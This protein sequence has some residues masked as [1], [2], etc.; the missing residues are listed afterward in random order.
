M[1]DLFGPLGDLTLAST[2]AS[3]SDYEFNESIVLLVYFRLLN[4]VLFKS[5]TYSPLLSLPES[6]LSLAKEDFFI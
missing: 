4:I 2:W 5:Y 1:R 3:K 6:G